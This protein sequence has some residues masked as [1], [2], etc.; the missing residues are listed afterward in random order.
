VSGAP[1]RAR[2]RF[3]SALDCELS[4]A[5]TAGEGWV[6][7]DPPWA[8]SSWRAPPRASARRSWPVTVTQDMQSARRAF[9]DLWHNLRAVTRE[10]RPDWDLSTLA[11]ARLGTRAARR[12]SRAGTSGDRP[13]RA[14]PDL[15]L[16]AGRADGKD[17]R[18]AM[19]VPASQLLGVQSGHGRRQRQTYPDV[20]TVN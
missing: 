3:R 4:D 16:R 14:P 17:P 11:Y 9:V 13:L 7:I 2:S 15:H 6:D 19:P 5:E 12:A 20:S 18:R 1:R 10:I 8:W